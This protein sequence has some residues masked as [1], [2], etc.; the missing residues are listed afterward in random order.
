[1]LRR[2]RQY[3]GDGQVARGLLSASVSLLPPRSYFQPGTTSS[4]SAIRVTVHS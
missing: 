4:T 2:G 3:N 1:M